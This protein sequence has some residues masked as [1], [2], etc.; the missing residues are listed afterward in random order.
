[1]RFLLDTNV[2]SE[3]TK[4]KPNAGVMAWL[5]EVEEDSVFVSVVSFTEFRYGIERLAESTRRR[6]FERWLLHD[7][8]VRFAGR[9]LPVDIEVAEA[10]GRLIARS[11]SIGRPLDD[12]DAF[13]AAT[14]Q[15]HGLTLVTR[16]VSDFE[17]T[18]STL[19]NP[20]T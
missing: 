8:P 2:V 12:R 11:E 5:A 6:R 15:V 1:M 7:L 3:P 20:W 10:S 17:P 13:I 4:P 9:I 14:A 18:I 19:I 16:N